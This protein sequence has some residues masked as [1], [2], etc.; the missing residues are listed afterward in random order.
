MVYHLDLRNQTAN[1]IPSHN[2]LVRLPALS[3]GNYLWQQQAN[4]EFPPYAS[5][6]NVISISGSQEYPALPKNL[7]KL[8]HDP[9]P[10]DSPLLTASQLSLEELI[11]WTHVKL[12]YTGVQKTPLTFSQLESVRKG[13]CTEF[14]LLAYQKLIS[15]GVTNVIPVEGFY[16]PNAL[17]RKITASNYHAWLLVKHE[18]EWLVVDPLYKKIAKPSSEYIVMNILE[19]G[20]SL[21]LIKNSNLLVR[22]K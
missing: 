15:Q 12:E 8:L 19:E 2:W 10:I 17:S 9:K 3:S 22:L 16:L 7:I 1:S 13:D 18:G 4:P 20:V 5:D 11:E 6:E 14:T 21:P